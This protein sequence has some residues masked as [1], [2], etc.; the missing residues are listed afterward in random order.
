MVLT[1]LLAQFSQ[2]H[3]PGAHGQIPESEPQLQTVRSTPSTLCKSIPLSADI[4]A[5]VNSF[6]YL[7]AGAEEVRCQVV[8]RV[9]FFG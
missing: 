2:A 9:L 8:G 7:V 6:L 5:I 1:S 3:V 4:F